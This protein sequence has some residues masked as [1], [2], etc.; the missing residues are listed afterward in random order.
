MVIYRAPAWASETGSTPGPQ[1]LESQEEF[2]GLEFRNPQGLEY[3]PLPGYLLGQKHLPQ[4]PPMGTSG[5]GSGRITRLQR[6]AF[7]GKNSLTVSLGISNLISWGPRPAP[8]T[9][10]ELQ[11]HLPHPAQAGPTLTLRL[12][13]RGSWPLSSR[14]LLPQGLSHAPALP[15]WHLQPTDQAQ[16]RGREIPATAGNQCGEGPVWMGSNCTAP[17]VKGTGDWGTGPP[18]QPPPSSGLTQKSPSKE[19]CRGPLST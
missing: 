11:E 19:T 14:T 1:G 3:P 13:C 8:G 10:Q 12:G 9:Q 2:Q 4:S 5:R 6:G 7:C 15:T 17:K 18:G 16:L